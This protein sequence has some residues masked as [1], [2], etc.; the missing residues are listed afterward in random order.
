MNYGYPQPYQYQQTYG[1]YQYQPPQ[2]QQIPRQSVMQQP[3][4]GFSCRPVADEA[5]ARVIPTD[6]NGTTMVLVD[7]AHGCIY[8]KALNHFDGLPVFL[9]YRLE[10]PVVQAPVEYATTDMV[11]KLQAELRDLKKLLEIEDG[12]GT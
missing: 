10:E 1:T 2:A 11:A 4:T 6:F 5:E 12:G 7:Q 9:K 3:V 8:T